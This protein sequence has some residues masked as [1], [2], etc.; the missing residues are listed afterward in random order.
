MSY[1]SWI[2]AVKSVGLWVE[3]V[4]SDKARQK[5][6]IH[7]GKGRYKEKE[8]GP[9]VAKSSPDGETLL[10]VE[11]GDP[12][13]QP[14]KEPKA[15]PKDG[16]ETPK[17][18]SAGSYT[19]YK[20]D[21]DKSLD[22]VDTL[23]SPTFTEDIDPSDEDYTPPKG[24]ENPDP[25]PPYQM[26]E[27]KSGKFPKKYAKAIERMMNSTK[28]GEKPITQDFIKGVGAGQ[29]GSQAGEVLTVMAT[30]L[31]K[32]EWDALKNSLLEYETALITQNKG[33][34]NPKKRIID[35]SW[36]EAADNNRLA[37]ERQVEGMYGKG[38]KILSTGWDVKADVEAM[39]WKDRYKESKGYSTDMYA[40]VQ[41]P[42]G[43]IVMHEPSLKKDDRINFINK[44]TGA[45]KDW[46]GGMFSKE[47][48][49][50]DPEKLSN[51]ENDRLKTTD[52]EKIKKVEEMVQKDPLKSYMKKKGFK[53]DQILDPTS[54]KGSTRHKKKAAFM[55]MNMM[56]GAPEYG[57]QETGPNKGKILL[58]DPP[59]KEQLA[60]QEHIKDVRNYCDNATREIAKPRPNPLREGML[61]AISEEFPLKGVADQEETMAIGAN[62][63][64]PQTMEKIF[65]TSDFDEIKEDLVVDDSVTPPVLAYKGG[66]EGEMLQIA[67]IGIRQDGIGYG[68]PNIKFEM[69]MDKDFAE[70]LKQANEDVYGGGEKKEQYESLEGMIS[71]MKRS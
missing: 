39:G 63:L 71:R 30:G 48:E 28:S 2:E 15:E 70:K 47:N 34:R 49:H 54:G 11:P 22:D 1:T 50:L 33:L 46:L 16:E 10:K 64:D 55:A 24:L 8:D 59:T 41:L 35:K 60:V 56:A 19:G 68:A 67:K 44:T 29:A 62:S 51:R 12:E 31:D 9:V 65:G 14:E 27:L 3:S 18:K 32:E 6:L 17:T 58:A 5:G 38:A 40:K 36:I 53:I 25:P 13:A 23:K 57:Y 26:P 42:D 45:F 20:G 66:P 37:I 43:S 4:A 7:V 52:P 61:K 69:T 21:K